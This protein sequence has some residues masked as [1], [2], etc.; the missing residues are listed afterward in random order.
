MFLSVRVEFGKL[1]TGSL[2][3]DRYKNILGYHRV[4][5][6]RKTS[7]SGSTEVRGERGILLDVIMQIVGEFK[8]SSCAE[9][10]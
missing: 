10:D 6:Q 1:N 2:N 3:D 8:E 9:H 5:V 7:M 4:A